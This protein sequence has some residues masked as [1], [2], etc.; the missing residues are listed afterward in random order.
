MFTVIRSRTRRY[1]Y[2]IQAPAGV[3]WAIG[4]GRSFGWYRYKRDAEQRARELNN[5]NRQGA[6]W[7]FHSP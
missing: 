5:H 1:G 3:R 2:A 4:P 7:H 6:T